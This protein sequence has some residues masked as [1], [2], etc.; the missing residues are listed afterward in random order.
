[1]DKSCLTNLLEFMELLTDEVDEGSLADRIYFN[2]AQAFDK[3]PHQ[4]S[5]AKLE[6]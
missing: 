2:F 5:L 1:M 6:L 3:V 4:K